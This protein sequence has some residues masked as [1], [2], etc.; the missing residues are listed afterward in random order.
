MNLLPT[1]PLDACPENHPASRNTRIDS[2]L[3]EREKKQ[4]IDNF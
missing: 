2:L 1:I 3:I 4:E